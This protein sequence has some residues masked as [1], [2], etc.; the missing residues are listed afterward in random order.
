MRKTTQ[1]KQLM[2]ARTAVTVPGGKTPDP[3]RAALAG[4]GFSVVLYA[5]AAL[6]AELRASYDVLEA[7]KATGSLASVRGSPGN[8]RRNDNGPWRS[9]AG[10]TSSALYKTSDSR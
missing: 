6:Q 9:T 8:V 4:M 10:T 1:L 3:G 7:L 5:N 2:A